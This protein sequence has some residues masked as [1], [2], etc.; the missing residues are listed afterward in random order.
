MPGTMVT[1]VGFHLFLAWH[2]VR[3][4]D[5]LEVNERPAQSLL[6]FLVVPFFLQLLKF[7]FVE[8]SVVGQGFFLFCAGYLV[9]SQAK[10]VPCVTTK[11]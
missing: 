1:R 2:I 7:V 8:R 10:F 11:H 5:W 3:A 6:A 9:R 4:S